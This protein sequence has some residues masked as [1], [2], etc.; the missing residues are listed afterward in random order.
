[1]T[2]YVWMRHPGLPDNAPVEQP[3][4]AFDARYR[5]QGWLECEAP[6]GQTQ[7]DLDAAVAGFNAEYD[8]FIGRK[9]GDVIAESAA[10]AKAGPP[11]VKE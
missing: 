7:A 8:H 1:M 5:H 9:V 11:K 6:A 3:R 2:G 10:R 4:A